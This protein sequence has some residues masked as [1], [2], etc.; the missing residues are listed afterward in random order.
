MKRHYTRKKGI[1]AVLCGE[2]KIEVVLWDANS[3]IKTAAGASF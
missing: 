3:V 2:I 1:V